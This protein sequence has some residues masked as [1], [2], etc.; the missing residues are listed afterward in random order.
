MSNR[1][2][3][4]TQAGNCP[5]PTV[6]FEVENPGNLSLVYQ[7]TDKS[8][9]GMGQTISNW[10]WNFGD[11]NTNSLQNPSHVYANGGNYNVSLTVTNSCG[12]QNQ[13]TINN[14][15]S[16]IGFRPNPNG[17]N[18]SNRITNIWP[19][20][21][22]TEFDN[23]ADCEED[24]TRTWWVN[25]ENSELSR[26]ERAY[27]TWEI[28]SDVF[29]D[30]D[31][32]VLERN[33]SI[34]ED[35]ENPPTRTYRGGCWGFSFSSLL[36]Y[37]DILELNGFFSGSNNV[38]DVEL[39][40][41]V[42]FFIQRYQEF[43]GRGEI[44]N[45]RSDVWDF[46]PSETLEAIRNGFN[47]PNNNSVL[48]FYDYTT[49]DEGADDISWGHAVV[50][51]KIE[52]NPENS[53]EQIIFIYDPNAPFTE[54][55]PENSLRS[56]IINTVENTWTYPARDM[57]KNRHIIPGI[58]INEVGNIHK[59]N[60]SEYLYVESS[61]YEDIVLIDSNNLKFLTSITP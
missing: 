7:F 9:A 53:N 57:T 14:C 31:P 26:C 40:D 3:T 42:R 18:F 13:T 29:S 54:E 15:I 12:E 47:T 5:I 35:L 24:I 51:Y 38:T 41:D 4:I 28:Y 48:C 8:Q 2:L 61:F 60:K 49:D 27:P 46:T 17:Y 52:I 55:N 11:G 23:E 6:G 25:E 50:P 21:I 30:R 32:A 22:I 20:F 45:H 16:D 58:P 19:D 37:N 34:L 10:N 43:Q 39:D 33:W 59:S 1:T 36:F 44:Q 56:I